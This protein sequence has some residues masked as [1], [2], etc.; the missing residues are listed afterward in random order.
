MVWKVSPVR[1]LNKF[2][3]EDD[4]HKVCSWSCC[5]LF[6]NLCTGTARQRSGFDGADDDMRGVMCS[7]VS[8]VKVL[9]QLFKGEHKTDIV[10]Q[11]Q[12]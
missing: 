7:H 3:R 4:S 12:F 8:I 1:S 10:K 2:L 6:W 5:T 11:P 9:S